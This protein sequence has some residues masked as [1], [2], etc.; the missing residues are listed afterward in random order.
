MRVLY[1]AA[2]RIPTEKAH[3]AQIMHTCAAL[4]RAGTEVELVVPGRATPIEQDPFDYYGV[5]KNFTLTTLRVTDLISWG[6]F[7]FLL[8]SISFAR[9]VM[10]HALAAQFDVVY[11]RDK[12]VLLVLQWLAPQLRLV[13]EVHGEESAWVLHRLSDA[14]FV[15][16]SQGLK[17]SL[18][19]EGVPQNHIVVAHDG[20]DLAPFARAES[21]QVARRRLGLPQDKKIALYVGRLDGWKGTNTLLEAVSLLPQVVVALIGGE[22]A[23][24]GALQKKFPHAV[25]LGPRPY[26]ELADNLAAADVLVL[27]NTAHDVT[28]QRYTSPLKLFAYLAA[29]KPIVASDLPSI[30]E[31]LSEREAFLVPPD[32]A[33]ALVHG[34]EQ[35]LNSPEVLTK[36]AAAGNKVTEYT[37]DA[38]AKSI[39]TALTQWLR[40]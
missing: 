4:A 6:R 38:R 29:R 24:V 17:D 23:Q 37:W 12:V 7:G 31:V 14:R 30:R 3:G 9:R 36:T 10:A 5:E 34:V 26:K 11:S 16:I 32:N 25:F 1:A 22:P 2:I 40:S 28:S 39:F 20:I 18:I 35:A 19:T 8:T 27:P 21:Q 33:V 15:A 13:F